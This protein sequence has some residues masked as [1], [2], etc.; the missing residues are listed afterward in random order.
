MFF[1]HLERLRTD[2]PNRPPKDH[3]RA[4]FPTMGVNKGGISRQE[5]GGGY[6]SLEPYISQPGRSLQAGGC[7]IGDVQH[8]TPMLYKQ[9][10]GVM[11]TWGGVAPN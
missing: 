11:Y 6:G 2:H 9:A 5:V 1:C 3:P 4:S 7:R 8:P 10:S